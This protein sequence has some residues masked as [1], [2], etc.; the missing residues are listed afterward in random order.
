MDQSEAFVRLAKKVRS[1]P[2]EVAFRPLIAGIE[3]L[4]AIAL[5]W[6]EPDAIPNRSFKRR[7]RWA[8]SVPLAPVYVWASSK[9]NVTTRSSAPSQPNSGGVEN[10]ALDGPD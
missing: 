7:T 1:E 5:N 10:G 2:N 8:T 4:V 3:A 6:L 9:T